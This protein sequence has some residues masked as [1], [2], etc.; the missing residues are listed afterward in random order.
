MGPALSVDVDGARLAVGESLGVKGTKVTA[1][2]ESCSETLA[3]CRRALRHAGGG[4]LFCVDTGSCVGF[5]AASTINNFMPAQ[6]RTGV[7]LTPRRI[8]AMNKVDKQNQVV[9]GLIEN[10]PLLVNDLDVDGPTPWTLTRDGLL[11]GGF[12]ILAHRRLPMT[13]TGAN[14]ARKRA[15]VLYWRAAPGEEPVCV[16]RKSLHHD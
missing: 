6:L 8:W 16:V 1:N 9:G 10:S 11:E 15:M 13:E 12:N 14:S 7:W 2:L 3:A 4:P 5:S